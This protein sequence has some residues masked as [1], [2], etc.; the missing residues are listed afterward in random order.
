[1]WQWSNY[2]HTLASA[3][4]SGVLHVNLD[5]PHILVSPP[6]LRGNAVSV[7]VLRHRRR[8]PPSEMLARPSSAS[9]SPWSRS[10][11]TTRLCNLC[12]HR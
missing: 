9:A 1:M 8:K 2:L 5:E 12:C 6:A 4:G 3:C 10:F 11:A 7:T